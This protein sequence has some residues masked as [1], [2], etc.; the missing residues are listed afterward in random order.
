MA[1]PVIETSSTSASGNSAQ[2]S[3][4][5]TLPT[6]I[7]ADDL[8][9]LSMTLDAPAGATISW[10]AGYTELYDT[11]DDNGNVSGSSAY[12]FA[13]GT[14]GSTISVTTSAARKSCGRYYRISGCDT[15]VAPEYALVTSGGATTT[16]NPPAVTPSGGSDDYVY[17]ALLQ[18]NTT[19]TINTFPTGYTGTGHVQ[20]FTS[21]ATCGTAWAY[22][23][24]TGS[25]TEDP[26]AFVI[27]AARDAIPVTIA[28]APTSAAGGDTNVNANAEA[29][30][31]TENAATITLD[32]NVAAS[33]ESLTLT[34][35][36][37]TVGYVPSIDV[38]V[39]AN[40][41]ALTITEHQASISLGVNVSAST[42]SLVLTGHTA[43]VEL[44]VNVQASAEALTIT[45]YQAVIDVGGQTN[46]QAST[47]A[48]VITPQPAS[49]GRD[50]NV[51]ASVEAL[52]LT[53]N[54]ASVQLGSNVLASIASLT[55]TEQ[56]ATITYDVGVEASPESLTIETHAADI[57][58]QGATTLTPQDITNIVDALFAKVVE[59][60]ETFE[61]Q[62]KL[63]RAEA[64]GKVAVS[65]NTVSF[66]D[67]ADSKDR[68]V[69]TVD[70]Q[71][72]RT[73][74]T[75]DVS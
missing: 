21:G 52:T 59:N 68:I 32:V 61:Q 40:T 46:V 25:S 2:S 20:S 4:S 19:V 65:G 67:A 15:A 5:I 22:K 43:Q 35:Y 28:V 3:H 71:G 73:A 38:D 13:D 63:I 44:D 60:G 70:E 56:P 18:H 64:A 74:I 51:G 23:G 9:L 50:V 33:T 53:T 45:S 41:E 12:R 10:P 58:S 11:E 7:A 47:E 54:A 14:E 57:E 75:T 37:A 42:E 48:L 39:L 6:G 24:T 16:H 69:A 34:E 31:I 36:Q 8:I 49:I 29:L 72:Q 1:T 26:S 17:F 62:L 66:R 27:S 30:T 55:I